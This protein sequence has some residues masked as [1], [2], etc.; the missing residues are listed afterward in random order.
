MK[1]LL[2]ANLSRRLA[3]ALREA[4]VD[5]HHVRAHLPAIADDFEVAALANR[6]EAALVTKDN[7]FRDLRW[8]AVL[9]VPLVWLRIGNM[10]N[11][12]TASLMLSALP[13]I[14]AAIDRGERTV[15]IR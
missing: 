2:D 8:R 15:E 3:S 10:S 13:A 11:R 14:A 4:G 1:L 6:L 5:C 9:R 12:N 7:D